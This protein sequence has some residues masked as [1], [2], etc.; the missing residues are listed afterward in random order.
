MKTAVRRGNF[1]S[2][3]RNTRQAVVSL[4]GLRGSTPVMIAWRI[5]TSMI[6]LASLF[7]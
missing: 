6:S 2:R 7:R 4:N 3:A 1:K 5:K